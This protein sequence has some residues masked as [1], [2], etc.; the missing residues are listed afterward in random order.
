MHSLLCYAH[1]VPRN[2]SRMIS[3][4]ELGGFPIVSS[5]YMDV[6]TSFP[7]YVHTML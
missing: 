5:M 6:C 4:V 3:T 2:P 1:F 7:N